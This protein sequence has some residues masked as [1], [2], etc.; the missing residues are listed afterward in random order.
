[1]DLGLSKG[2]GK[3]PHLDWGT[4]EGSP[5]EPALEWRL[6]GRVRVS[7]EKRQGDE[8]QE[9]ENACALSHHT[10]T[11]PFSVSNHPPTWALEIRVE[12]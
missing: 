11:Y 12:R 4:Q 2:E 10:H 8:F 9:G 5:K 6:E 3:E 7:W 1:M